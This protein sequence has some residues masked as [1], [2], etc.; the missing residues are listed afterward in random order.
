M[1][2]LNHEVALLEMRTE[3]LRIHLQSVPAS[4]TEARKLRCV[5][6]A[7]R[8][9]IRTLKRFARAAGVVDRRRC[10]SAQRYRRIWPTHRS[11]WP[12]PSCPLS[13]SSPAAVAPS[14]L[15]GRVLAVA[16]DR[17][18]WP[19]NAEERGRCLDLFGSPL[20]STLAPL[21]AGHSRSSRHRR[22]SGTSQP[23][24]FA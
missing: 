9:K 19:V 21:P 17:D 14:P 23:I 2:S 22:G 13:A 4:S 5:L 11:A 12:S 20:A 18:A 7:M 8:T 16:L 3:Q 6:S 1:E 15:D 24:R 10:T